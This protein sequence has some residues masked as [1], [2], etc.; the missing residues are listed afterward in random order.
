MVEKVCEAFYINLLKSLVTPDRPSSGV[1]EEVPFVL[2]S[3]KENVLKLTKI[4][5]VRGKDRI[6]FIFA[7]RG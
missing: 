3:E 6:Y 4:D 5:K 1:L 2:I 7:H